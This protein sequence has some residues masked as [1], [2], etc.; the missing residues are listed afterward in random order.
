MT[1]TLTRV[2]SVSGPDCITPNRLTPL[3]G[4]SRDQFN[5][6]AS[7]AKFQPPWNPCI[8]TPAAIVHSAIGPTSTAMS[9]APPTAIAAIWPAGDRRAADASPKC[10][11]VG[12]QPAR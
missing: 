3:A 6:S 1:A 5:C 8:P 9:C 12:R 11:E 2:L 4:L 10:D 7:G